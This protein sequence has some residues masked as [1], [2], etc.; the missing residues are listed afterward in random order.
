[1][2]T[3]QVMHLMHYLKLADFQKPLAAAATKA[4]P[5]QAGYLQVLLTLLITPHTYQVMHTGTYSN[6]WQQQ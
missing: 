6:H 1:M 3:S 4:V 5:N 2:H